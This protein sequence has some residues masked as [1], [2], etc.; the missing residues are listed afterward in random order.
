M[1][2]LLWLLLIRPQRRA[3]GASSSCSRLEVGDEILTAGGLYG[4]VREIGDDDELASRSR[5]ASRVADGAARGRRRDPARGRGR[6]GRDRR[7]CRGEPAETTHKKVHRAQ[8]ERRRT[9]A[10]LRPLPLRESSTAPHP[11]SADRRRPGRRRLCSSIPGS[12]LQKEPTLGL[13]LQGGLEVT[14]QAV[15]PKNRP[16]QKSDLDRS[17]EILRDRIDKLGVAEPEIRKQGDDQ[18]VDR[19]PRR[20]GPRTQSSRSSAR[21]RSSSSTTSRRTSSG[22]SIDAQRL[23]G[24]DGLDLR[25]ARRPAGARQGRATTRRVVPLRRQEEARR[26]PDSAT[27]RGAPARREVARGRRRRRDSCP[28]GWRVFGVPPN[29]VVI[30][31]GTARSSA[32]ASTREPDSRTTTTCS[33][34]DRVGRR[35]RGRSVPE[36]TGEDLQ[37]AGHAPGLRHADRRADRDDAV[38][39]RAAGTSSATSPPRSPSAAS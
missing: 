9:A 37:L 32:R 24:R 1:F 25:A 18:I 3:P 34:Y 17:V 16:L 12:P 22:P 33:S 8:P 2:A 30:E 19:P 15:P 11:R 36:M 29:T 10:N 14:L 23:P 7:G 5:P 6:G 39:G 20:R 27:Q 31:C 21:P 26:R 13:D 38:H 35:R 28:K 4:F